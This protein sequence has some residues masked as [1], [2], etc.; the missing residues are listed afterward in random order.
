MD[1]KNRWPDYLLPI[2]IIACLMVIF[3]PLPP[4]VMDLLLAANI[5]V[6]VVVL[7]TTIYVKTPLELSIFPSLL[8]GTTLARLAL[9]IGTT[10]LILTRGATDHELAAGGVIQSFSQ[11]VTGDSIIVGLVIFSI[12]VVVQFVVIT[13]GATRI[14]EVAARFA[15]DGMPGKQMAIDAELN[16]G[17]RRSC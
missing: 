2:G 16:A 13:K 9:N 5:S 7:L 1:F 12:I 6:A 8:L 11:F 15:L 4:A 17:C 14:S 3:A 10:R